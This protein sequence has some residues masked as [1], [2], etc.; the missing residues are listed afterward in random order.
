[1]K[2]P[3]SLFLISALFL[4]ACT[5]G[6]SDCTYSSA[7]M[8]VFINDRMIDD[9][10]I[11]GCFVEAKHEAGGKA[12]ITFRDSLEKFSLHYTD[13]KPDSLQNDALVLPSLDI[14]L[15]GSK[16]T[17]DS[18]RGHRILAKAQEHAL[19]FSFG[20]AAD[21]DNRVSGQVLLYK[22]P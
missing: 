7:R 17:W 14:T 22:Q 11:K 20:E 6:A 2:Y 9:R 12:E 4:T 16:S 19:L 18:E 21:K 5:S 3:R 8:R 13:G 15:N 10:E 1:M